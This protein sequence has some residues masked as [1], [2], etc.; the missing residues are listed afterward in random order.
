[1]TELSIAEVDKTHERLSF[2][3]ESHQ[4]YQDFTNDNMNRF[5][6]V[7]NRELEVLPE[8]QAEYETT[9]MLTS[10]S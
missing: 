1:M 4:M 9:M 3:D 5:Y 2:D 6:P 7:Q 8:Q 10:K